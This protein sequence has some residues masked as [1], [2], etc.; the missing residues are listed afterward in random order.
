MSRSIWAAVGACAVALATM[1]GVALAQ[2]SDNS[3]QPGGSTPAAATQPSA[4]RLPHHTE[5]R[6]QRGRRSSATRAGHRN[7]Y[8]LVLG[9]GYQQA[10]GSSRV[11][12]L[13]RQLAHLGFAPGP[14]DGRYGPLTAGSVERFQATADLTVDGVAGP[15]TLAAITATRRAVV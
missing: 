13:Q 3:S 4:A 15:H 2:G 9:S 5:Y 8:L 7:G 12:A 11:R 10:A 1:P 14:I 6:L